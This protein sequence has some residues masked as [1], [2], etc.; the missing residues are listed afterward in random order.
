MFI[1]FWLIKWVSFLWR[2]LWN[3][4]GYLFVVVDSEDVVVVVV[5][6]GVVIVVGVVGVVG[7]VLFV[8]I[9]VES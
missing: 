9:V 1:F 2:K 3:W 8:I 5:G 7:V 6:L 4:K